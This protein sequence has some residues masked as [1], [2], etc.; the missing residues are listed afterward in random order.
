MSAAQYGAVDNLEV[1]SEAVRY[2]RFLVDA[3]LEASGGSSTAVDFGAGTGSLSVATRRR[4]LDVT[5]VEQ[6][7]ALRRRLREQNLAVCA[8]LEDLVDESQEFIYSLNV[9][10]H[11]EDDQGAL[12]ALHSKLKSGGRLFLYVPAFD[13]LFSSMDRKVGHYRR[14]RK[15]GLI[16]IATGAGSVAVS[17]RPTFPNTWCTSGNEAIIRSVCWSSSLALVMEIPGSVVGI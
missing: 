2:N 1:L 12:E 4:G 3:V 15:R 10:E 13:V 8:D 11:I 9:L 16:R 5:C 6:D 17:A 14:Y 7:T